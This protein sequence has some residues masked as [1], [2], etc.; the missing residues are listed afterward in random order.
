MFYSAVFDFDPEASGS[1]PHPV[2]LLVHSSELSPVDGPTL[3][4]V[5][6]NVCVCVCA[7]NVVRML[8]ITAGI[9]QCGT[10][11]DSKY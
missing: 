2:L 11:P 9:T 7:L 1:P 4:E 10:W 8:H 5:G 6:W 3:E